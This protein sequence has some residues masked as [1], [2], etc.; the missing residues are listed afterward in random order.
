MK[1]HREEEEAKPKQHDVEEAERIRQMNA[2][3][4]LPHLKEGLK[5]ELVQQHEGET[6]TDEPFPGLAA[7]PIAPRFEQDEDE[8]SVFPPSPKT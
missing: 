2:A 5:L 4:D 1:K 3:A 7:L 8:M 6:T